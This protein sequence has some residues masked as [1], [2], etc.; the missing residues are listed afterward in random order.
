MR[1]KGIK[2]TPYGKAVYMK[3]RTVI[4]FRSLVMV[5]VSFPF[6]NA[7]IRQK[8]YNFIIFT[9]HESSGH[10]EATLNL[11]RELLR[12]LL[13]GYYVGVTRNALRARYVRVTVPVTLTGNLA[14]P[15][16]RDACNDHS[17][18]SE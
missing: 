16:S 11:L 1:L 4:A 8:V 13:R 12:E 6:I 15:P 9:R 3:M 14:D 10:R 2:G 17:S 18:L 7:I 5:V